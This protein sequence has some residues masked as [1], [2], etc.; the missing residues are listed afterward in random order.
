M[1]PMNE[2]TPSISRRSSSSASKAATSMASAAR[3]RLRPALSRIARRIAS[4][5][6]MPVATSGQGLALL[7]GR[8]AR[9]CCARSELIPPEVPGHQ[10]PHGRL[11]ARQHRRVEE[12]RRRREVES[13]DGRG[14][15]R[16]AARERRKVPFLLHE[17]Q[18]RGVVKH[19]RQ[20]A[21]GPGVRRDDDRG[22][23]EPVG[24]I[25][26]WPADQR[27]AVANVGRKQRLENAPQP[28]VV[29]DKAAPWHVV[30]RHAAGGA[31]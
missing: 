31:T 29:R 1:L 19:L 20:D 15:R 10:E 30:R 13:A 4:D 27:L 28:G 3:R 9:G 26:Q 22:H 12:G 16:V 11:G 6:L 17:L 5:R 14:R 18:H 24:V 2:A 8:G 23:A 7:Q 25:G 21:A